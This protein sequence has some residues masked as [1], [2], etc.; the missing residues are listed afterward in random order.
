MPRC[1]WLLLVVGLGLSL[2]STAPLDLDLSPN[3]RLV[4]TDNALYSTYYDPDVSEDRPDLK[5]RFV[6]FADFRRN[7][8]IGETDSYYDYGSPA[9]IGSNRVVVSS[10]GGYNAQV[11]QVVVGRK[12]RGTPFYW[13]PGRD[14][15]TNMNTFQLADPELNRRGDKLAE[16]RRP[17]LGADAGDPTV[18]SIQIYRVANP[19]SASTPL[20]EIG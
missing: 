6:D 3:G 7:K 5:A 2:A 15:V 13:D 17:A 9:W 14:P 10:Y 16:M 18:A 20:C 12:S 4:A 19:P 11:L 1:G 8:V